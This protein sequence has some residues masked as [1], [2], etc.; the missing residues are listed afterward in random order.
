MA[1]NALSLSPGLKSLRTATSYGEQCSLFTDFMKLARKID[2][3]A[4]GCSAACC[5]TRTRFP[6]PCWERR[7]RHGALASRTD[8]CERSEVFSVQEGHDVGHVTDARTMSAE[9]K[10]TQKIDESCVVVV[11]YGMVSPRSAAS[12]LRNACLSF[13]E[14][15]GWKLETFVTRCADVCV[16]SVVAKDTVSAVLFVVATDTKSAMVKLAQKNDESA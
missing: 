4:S 3:S 7:H 16:L 14:N 6:R 8:V 13:Q 1:R 9:V 11:G 15:A 5:P 10:L 12:R 2:E